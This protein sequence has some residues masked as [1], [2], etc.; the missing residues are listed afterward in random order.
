MTE[1]CLGFRSRL[2]LLQM[3]SRG[4]MMS[5]LDHDRIVP[6]LSMFSCL[7][8]HLLISL[9]DEEFYGEEKIENGR[10]IKYIVC[11]YL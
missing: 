2:T 10:I 7:F 9:H 1:N 8:S 4:M 3:L 5:P 11:A 6:L